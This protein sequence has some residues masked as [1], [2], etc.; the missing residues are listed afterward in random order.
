MSDGEQF[1]LQAYLSVLGDDVLLGRAKEVR[2]RAEAWL[3]YVPQTFPHY[4]RHTVGHSEEII[5]QLSKLL[6][7]EEDPERPVISLSAIEAYILLIAAYLHDSGMVVSD[8]EKAEILRSEPWHD[9]TSEGQPGYRRW[10]EV[11][12][13]RNGSD[14]VDDAV[15]H[16]LAD[17]QTRFL[18]AE[19]IRRT[20]HFR[21]SE[22]IR[23][24]GLMLGNP[25]L[26]DPMLGR[27]ISNVCIAHGLDPYELEDSERYPDR[28]DVHGEAVNVRLVSIL[29]R[30]GDLLD[31][32]TDR[33]CPLLLSAACPLPPESLA[34]WSQYQRIIHRLTA[35]DRIEVIGEC[36]TQDEHRVLQDWC[37]WL[38]DE[39]YHASRLL[40]QS[41]RHSGWSA[42]VATIGGPSATIVIR[43]APAA[44]YFPSSWQFELD[45]ETVFE[46][47][48][49]DLYGSPHSFL[50]ELIQNALDATRCRTYREL[51]AQG[52]EVPEYP[53]QLPE[54]LRNKH[55]VMIRLESRSVQNDL[56]GELEERQFLTVSDDGIGMDRTDIE[57]YL[58]QVGRSFYVTPEFRRAYGFVA[59]SRFGVG[60]LSVFAASDHVVVE[61]L[62]DATEP[63]PI[64]L[65]LTGPRNYLLTER[66]SRAKSGTSVEVRLREPWTPGRVRELVRGWCKR[67]EFPIRVEDLDEVDEILAE[68]ASD[69]E[70]TRPNVTQPNEAL[71]VQ[72]FPTGVP[73]LEGELYVFVRGHGADESWIDD[74]W[75]RFEYPKLHP[76]ASAPSVPSSLICFGGIALTEGPNWR[77]SGSERLDIRRPISSE[78]L[79]LGRR[80]GPFE[81]RSLE[82]PEIAQRWEEIL[83]EHLKGIAKGLRRG[84]L[85]I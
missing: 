45:P 73:G 85:G 78:W 61:T 14:P 50:R 31:M 81:G 37:Q 43:S 63:E 36:L 52:V 3:S 27:T 33:A 54:D 57:K 60:F 46:R 48:I 58:L 67:V 39:T 8:E 4:T 21:S 25:S 40:A 82:F 20:H 11:L 62:R 17:L 35:P 38:V 13:F 12:E 76:L 56:S 79:P 59:S 77:D 74:R 15:R 23:Q 41:Q 72:A 71:A 32:T 44:D 19:F 66:G 69:F 75:A 9:W 49:G 64:R 70:E 47:L 18:I 5:R 16:F 6:F 83:S 65:T 51:Q 24:H 30:L 68:S 1:A 53:S 28:A 22:V 34:H 10:A 42:P 7:H 29:L 84:R 2:D 80:L 26:S 55:T